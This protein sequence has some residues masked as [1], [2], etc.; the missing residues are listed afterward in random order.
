MPQNS[1][2]RRELFLS[3]VYRRDITDFYLFFLFHFDR[4]PSSVQ[5]TTEMDGNDSHPVFGSVRNDNFEYLHNIE[6]TA[7]IKH[8]YRKSILFDIL[9]WKILTSTDS[10]L[11][12]HDCS[13]ES[14]CYTRHES[15][16]DRF[17][18]R[19]AHDQ[20]VDTYTSIAVTYRYALF[21]AS[22]IQANA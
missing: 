1:L 4:M 17:L 18:L 19:S 11:G 6:Q 9:L 21:V 2:N 5:N 15:E 3:K 13:F 8:K 22:L 12:N 16:Q 10:C 7:S 20:C 14:R